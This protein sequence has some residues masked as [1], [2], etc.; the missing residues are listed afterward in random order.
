VTELN[1]KLLTDLARLAGKY[2]R[3]DW[4]QLAAWLDDERHREQLRALLIELGNASGTRRRSANRRGRKPSR[5]AKVRESVAK[6]RL[7]DPARADL[8][9]DVW[10]K[11][12]ERELLP[13][14]PAVRAFAEAMGA[15]GIA[16][17]RRDQAVTEL[18]ERLLELPTDTL[19]HRMRRTVV[20]DRELGEEYER[21]VRLILGRPAGTAEEET[22]R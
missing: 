19:E 1:P 14:M 2:K 20:E 18:M 10:L 12:R 11:L 4:E 15:K 9:D 13:T 5:T 6:I 21:W 16:S 17:T 22:A 8:L 7:T 3:K